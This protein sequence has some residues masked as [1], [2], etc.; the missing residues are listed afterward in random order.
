MH[1]YREVLAAQVLL[2]NSAIGLDSVPM[3]ARKREFVLVVSVTAC[4]ALMVV[5][6]AQAAL[7]LAM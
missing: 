4:L 3:S 2:A 5:T 7:S 1:K 6:A